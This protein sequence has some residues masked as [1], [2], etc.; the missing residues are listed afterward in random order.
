[1]IDP[2]SWAVI[3]GG[4]AL[5]RRMQAKQQ[6]STP[7]CAHCTKPAENHTKCCGTN[8]CSV[9]TLLWEAGSKPCRCSQKR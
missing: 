8:L 4:Y 6:S 3:C 9:H 5:S 1:M 2:L 7:T